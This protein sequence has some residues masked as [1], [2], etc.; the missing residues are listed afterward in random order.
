M[1]GI[2]NYMNSKSIT[3]LEFKNNLEI[4]YKTDV[5][6]KEN[7]TTSIPILNDFLKEFANVNI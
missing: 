2:L 7:I 1:I 5:F 4:L 6:R 3:P